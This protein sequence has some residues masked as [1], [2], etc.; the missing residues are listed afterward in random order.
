MRLAISIQTRDAGS[1]RY[2][3]NTGGC[4]KRPRDR[5][6][7]IP[8]QTNQLLDRYPSRTTRTQ[9]TRAMCRCARRNAEYR[10]CAPSSCAIGS[11]ISIVTSIPIPPANA[12]GLNRTELVRW[13][14][15][16]SSHVRTDSPNGQT[17]Q[18]VSMCM[19]APDRPGATIRWLWWGPATHHRG[20]DRGHRPR[21]PKRPAPPAG[22]DVH[23]GARQ[24]R[25]H[26]RM[27]VREPDPQDRER[28]DE[29]RDRTR[30]A[31]VEELPPVVQDG[32][33]PDERAE[34]A[35]AEGH[36]RPGQEMRR[37]DVHLVAARGEIMAELVTQQNGHQGQDVQPPRFARPDR[38]PREDEVPAVRLIGPVMSAGPFPQRR[39]ERGGRRGVGWIYKCVND[40]T[41]MEGSSPP[42]HQKPC[43]AHAGA[44]Y[45]IVRIPLDS[46]V[47]IFN[48]DNPPSRGSPRPPE[49]GV[50]AHVDIAEL[51][52][53]SVAELHA[54]AESLNITNYSGLR[55]QDLIFRIEQ[56]LLDTDTVLRGEG[57]LEILPE[58][59]GFLRSADWNYLYGPDDIY[60]SPSQIKRFDLRT[61][62]TITGQVRPPK[63]GER[64]LALLKVEV[65]N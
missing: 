61:G 49:H 40:F 47:S 31:D 44:L 4:P 7:T 22:I 55:K 48:Q 23:G 1:G 30:G 8:A 2:A 18:P 51:K 10:M 19:A 52:R 60:V 65:V 37:R 62:D 42:R 43:E 33:Q 28:D 41:V 26:H 63:E 27:T 38:R 54:M 45:L 15:C 34:R 35:D 13:S 11:R 12:R 3:S 29:S 53:K 9:K 57:V 46:Q 14:P 5:S 56:S 64:Y 59:Y 36:R 20:G 39:R 24:A 25:V 32:S 16:R 50:E 21:P 6:S 58:G 17:P